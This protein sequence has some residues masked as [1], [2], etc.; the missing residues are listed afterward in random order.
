MVETKDV[1]R[2]IQ[3]TFGAKIR[4]V[5]RVRDIPVLS[6]GKTDL[7]AVANHLHGN[8]EL[9]GTLSLQWAVDLRPRLAAYR[10]Y[11]LFTLD[12][13]P[14]LIL[15]TELSGEERLFPSITPRIHAA[16]WYERE[17][18][19]MFGLIAEGHPDLRRLVRHEHWPKGTHPL[20]K[21]FAWD[22]VM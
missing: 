10:I 19:D 17:I 2:G 4:R 5:D 3:E 12:G 11:Y 15:Q 16:K 9:R 8:P 18:R 13:G 6:L 22:H 7:P 20:K 14:R 21:D 1:V